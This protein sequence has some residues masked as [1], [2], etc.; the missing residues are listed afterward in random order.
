MTTSHWGKSCVGMSMTCLKRCTNVLWSCNIYCSPAK[1]GWC[2]VVPVAPKA[3]RHPV[4]CASMES[5]MYSWA[6]CG[7]SCSAGCKGPSK[8]C[9]APLMAI[10]L[11]PCSGEWMC[12][13]VEAICN[14]KLYAR[15]F[16]LKSLMAGGKGW[17]SLGT[18]VSKSL[19]GWG[20]GTGKALLNPDIL[21][22]PQH[23]VVRFFSCSKRSALQCVHL[24]DMA[25]NECTTNPST[26]S[27][28][29]KVCFPDRRAQ[30]PRLAEV[31]HSLTACCC[32]A[33]WVALAARLAEASCSLAACYCS[34]NWAALA[35]HLAEAFRSL[36]ACCCSVNWAAL[37]ARLAEASCSLAVCRCLADWAALAARLV[38]AFICLAASMRG[39]DL[40][41]TIV[42]SHLNQAKSLPIPLN[43]D[44]FV[45]TM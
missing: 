22:S 28:V 13:P 4:I 8:W 26:S 23:K 27:A 11:I 21:P 33:S 5:M 25:P 1:V 16:C 30:A 35:T 3:A 18:L 7:T 41:P 45:L 20:A 44:I 19:S 29:C 15:M 37:A 6:N 17:C 12:R 10:M 43:T 24:C 38:A 39:E 36:A 34:A 40:K 2:K 14:A 42:F 9:T 31:S 32:S